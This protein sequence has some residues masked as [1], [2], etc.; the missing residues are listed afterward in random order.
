MSNDEMSRKWDSFLTASNLQ[1]EKRIG[2]IEMLFKVRVA[3]AIGVLRTI[4]IGYSA[5][6]P[7][8]SSQISSACHPYPPPAGGVA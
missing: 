2:V 5:F 7:S 1:A 3:I 8:V 4:R 6:K